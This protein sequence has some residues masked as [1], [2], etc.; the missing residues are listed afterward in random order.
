MYVNESCR[1]L[2]GTVLRVGSQWGFH[3][4]GIT[5]RPSW[6]TETVIHATKGRG[7]ESTSLAEFAAGHP[8]EVARS[9]QSSSEQNTI[10]QRAY[11]QI[12]KPYALF[13]ANCEHFVNWVLS[14]VAYSKQLSIG[15]AAILAVCI[16]AGMSASRR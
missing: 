2:P 7:V 10:L 5:D 14:G 6:G 13:D 16:A 4:Y 15:I 3:H 12:G 8:V 1:Y 9:P 11:S